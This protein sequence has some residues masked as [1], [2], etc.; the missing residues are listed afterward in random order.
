ML[1]IIHSLLVPYFGLAIE[2]P[3]ISA[4]ANGYF[5]LAILNSI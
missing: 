5:P 4:H 1:F 3:Y 2:G